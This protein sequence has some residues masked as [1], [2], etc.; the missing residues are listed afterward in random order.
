MKEVF[1][2]V[3]V[4][5]LLGAVTVHFVS[6]VGSV[7]H[8]VPNG[9]ESDY[10][11]FTFRS[12]QNKAMSTNML[13][14]I[15]V[16]N[17]CLIF[18]YAF[19]E[20]SGIK[21]HN[22]VL[23]L[24]VFFYY[25]YR[26]VLIIGILN[27]RELFCFRYE[28]TCL[29]IGCALSILLVKCFLKDANQIFIPI[30]ELVNEFWLI[31]IL[32]IYK[33]LI[34]F[35]DKIFRQKTVV[36]ERMLDN[37]IVNKF[38]LFYKKFEDIVCVTDKDN[39]IWVLLFSIMI[40]EN[41][42]RGRF[43]RII[44]EIKILLGKSATVGIMQIKSDCMLS[45]KRSIEIA[46][47]RLKNQFE[48]GKIT[49]MDEMNVMGC[50]MQYNPDEDYAKSVSFIFQHLYEYIESS[51]KYKAKF[52]IVEETA[53]EYDEIVNVY[54]NVEYIGIDGYMTFDDLREESGMSSKEVWRKIRKEKLVIYLDRKEVQ[55]TLLKNK[56]Y[57]A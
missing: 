30:S 5:L 31:I 14:N 21:V 18:L 55:N 47:D 17:V 42:N 39:G 1:L 22:E 36:T 33:F 24:Y 3:L 28:I 46:Y 6:W 45:D 27:R 25:S 8:S 40:F 53:A 15:L 52:C 38:N 19:I 4:S 57:N 35:F 54:E 11:V 44:E 7:L 48:N 43:L 49:D 16:P 12:D 32:L 41:Y 10:A 29:L 34:L 20:K 56:N 2:E 9:G 26:I 13:M 50:A 23:L 37:Y 51:P